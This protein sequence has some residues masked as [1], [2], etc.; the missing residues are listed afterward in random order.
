MRILVC[1]SRDWN[2][3]EAIRF[4]IEKECAKSDWPAPAHVW[5]INGAARGADRLSSE[6]GEELHLGVHEV[7]AQWNMYGKGA[8]PIRNAE[9]LKMA[10]DVV[11]A[12]WDGKSKGTKNMMVHA[13]RAGV[14]VKVF[15]YK[16]GVVKE[17][18]WPL[19]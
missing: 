18:L 12:F 15:Q 4:A 2:D 6:V 17:E 11:L 13:H 10:P 9:M 8:G 3:K 14:P 16:Y 1:G 19:K 5:I 7:P